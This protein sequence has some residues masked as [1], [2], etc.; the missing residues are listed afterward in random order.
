MQITSGGAPSEYTVNIS[1]IL[2]LFGYSKGGRKVSGKCIK[3]TPAIP[4]WC[5]QGTRL[6]IA[7]RDYFYGLPPVDKR[8][9]W[10]TCTC[11]NRPAPFS[12]DNLHD[13]KGR[14]SV[15]SAMLLIQWNRNYRGLNSWQ[16]QREGPFSVFLSED[17]CRLTNCLSH[18]INSSH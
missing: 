13:W 11:R 4:R 8:N 5:L 7:A 10:L 15:V 16:R 1:V 6:S 2:V 14:S 18:F 12:P 3:G 9:F 17:L